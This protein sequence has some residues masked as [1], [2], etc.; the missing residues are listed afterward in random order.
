MSGRIP[1]TWAID[2]LQYLGIK[3]NPGLEGPLGPCFALLSKDVVIN[4]SNNAAVKPFCGSG[5]AQHPIAKQLP[6]CR[7]IAKVEK[8]RPCS[9]LCPAVREI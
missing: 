7:S 2:K 6:Q 5:S 1:C 3:G 8:V 9:L 4:I